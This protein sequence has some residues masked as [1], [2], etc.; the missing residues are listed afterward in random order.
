MSGEYYTLPLILG[1]LIKK[2]EHPKCPLI[3]SIAQN[4][5]LILTTDFG[6]N[7]NDPSYGC[8]IWE[9]EFEILLDVESWKDR[10]NDSIKKSLQKHEKRVINFDVKV[11]IK[12]EELISNKTGRDYRI[13][14]SV[15]I[16][17]TGNLIKTNESCSF[18]EKFFI[19]PISFD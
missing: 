5:H 13:K 17:I 10:L 11:D 4:I 12:Q 9:D 2:K 3:Q 16:S 8:S 7:R 14:R 6:E 1:D 19:G 15:N 18:F